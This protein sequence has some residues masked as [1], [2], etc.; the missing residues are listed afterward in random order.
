MTNTIPTVDG[1]TCVTSLDAGSETYISD[2]SDLMIIKGFAI[3]KVIKNY[4]GSGLLD[5]LVPNEDIDWAYFRK[6]SK[7]RHISKKKVTR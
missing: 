4:N 7:L 2:L 3:S 5:M 1:Y 6:E